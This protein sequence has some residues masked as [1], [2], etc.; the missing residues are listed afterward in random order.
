M[1][2]TAIAVLSVFTSFTFFATG[3]GSIINKATAEEKYE[4]VKDQA[5][6]VACLI[7]GARITEDAKAEAKV[8][9]D[10]VTTVENRVRIDI[11]PSFRDPY[12]DRVG[13]IDKEAVQGLVGKRADELAKAGDTARGTNRMGY[14]IDSN[15]LAEMIDRRFTKDQIKD[16]DE[17][18]RKT[19][20]TFVEKAADVSIHPL[21][22]DQI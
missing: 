18:F 22:V 13:R 7:I 8:A 5:N 1:G 20:D 19:L 10:F 12:R 14:R 9:S 15:R 2:A 4:R 21:L 16:A 11:R 17:Q 3:Q 6:S